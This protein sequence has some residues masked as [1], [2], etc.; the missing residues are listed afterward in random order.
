MIDFKQ[1]I[2]ELLSAHI[3]DMSTEEIYDTIEY[4]SMKIWETMPSH[5][6]SWQRSFA[7]LQT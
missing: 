1:T 5:A 2:A 3:D 4:P 7:R 6:S